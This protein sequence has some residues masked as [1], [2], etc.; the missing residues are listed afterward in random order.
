M[1]EAFQVVVECR[2]EADQQIGLRATDRRRIQVP[3]AD[4]VTEM[5][6]EGHRS[7]T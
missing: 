2:D 1:P 5:N 7:D 4:A 3:A 6:D